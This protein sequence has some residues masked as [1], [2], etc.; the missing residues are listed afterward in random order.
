[1]DARLTQ[2]EEKMKKSHEALEQEY[3]TIRA[4]RANPNMLDGIKRAEGKYI[5]VIGAGDLLYDENILENVYR[6]MERRNSRCCFGWAHGYEEHQKEIHKRIIKLPVFVNAYRKG[7]TK[8]IIKN[9]V[10]YDDRMAG[11]A[12]FFER[13]YP[14]PFWE[15]MV[16][17]GCVRYSEDLLTI[18][19]ALKEE[20]YDF[21]DACVVWYE[22][23]TG[24]SSKKSKFSSEQLITHDVYNYFNVLAKKYSNNPLLKRGL[25]IRMY[26]TKYRNRIQR[27]LNYYRVPDKFIYELIARIYKNFSYPRYKSQGFLEDEKFLRTMWMKDSEKGF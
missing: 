27:I 11:C 23:N 8:Q 10:K 25:K 15:T 5:K 14:I 3:V 6:F 12:L 20:C 22:T 18:E 21:Y 26:Q 19:M 7:K 24:V 9:I 4:G 2:Y 16:K 17:T 13:N 1:M